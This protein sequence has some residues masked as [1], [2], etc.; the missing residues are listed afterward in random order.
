V[1][2]WSPAAELRR[3][4]A[5]IARY[6]ADGQADNSELAPILIGLLEWISEHADAAADFD[7]IFVEAIDERGHAAAE[8]LK[9]CMHTLR[10]PGVRTR[11]E[12]IRDKAD[13]S[14]TGYNTRRGAERI[15]EAYSDDWEAIAIGL[16]PAYPNARQSHGPQAS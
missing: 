12:E 8:I 13:D 5:A 4:I 3:R 6:D 9:Y 15:L 10:Y 1:S 7:A 2:E 16:W 14:P 11:L